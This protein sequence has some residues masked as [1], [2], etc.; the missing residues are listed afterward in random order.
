MRIEDLSTTERLVDETVVVSAAE[1]HTFP[2]T[3]TPDEEGNHPR[4]RATV[5]RTD[6]QDI[7]DSEER[8]FSP[9]SGASFAARIQ[10]DGTIRVSIRVV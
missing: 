6:T 3:S 2:F 4:I 1:T 9:A 5:S 8:T 7:E 10:A